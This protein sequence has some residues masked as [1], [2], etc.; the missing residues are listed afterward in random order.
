MIK[1]RCHIFCESMVLLEYIVFKLRCPVFC[2]S[3]VFLEYV[4]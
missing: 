4:V 3:R 2:K 1:V